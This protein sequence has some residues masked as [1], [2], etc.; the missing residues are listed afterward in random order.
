VYADARTARVSERL[1]EE[2]LRTA[3]EAGGAVEPLLLGSEGSA[4]SSDSRHSDKVRAH[5]Y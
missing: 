5:V 3:L 4:A 2:A 1:T